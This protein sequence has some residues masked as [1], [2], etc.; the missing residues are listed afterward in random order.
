MKSIHYA[1]PGGEPGFA[2]SKVHS[3]RHP[4]Q[5][6]SHLLQNP[7]RRFSRIRSLCDGPSH[8]K[9]ASALAQSISWRRNTLLI[10]RFRSRWPNPRDDQH[11]VRARQHAQEAYL[12]RRTD[13]PP[14]PGFKTHLGQP[15]HLL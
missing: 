15:L 13:K 12:L 7:I 4:S 14:N 1:R 5:A 10:A 6:R 11:R 9:K 2:A 8:H 3:S